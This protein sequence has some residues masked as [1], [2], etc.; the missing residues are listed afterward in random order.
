M[1]YPG[2]F[3]A[4]RPLADNIAM[5][6]SVFPD[7]MYTPDES[8]KVHQETT[9]HMART[10]AIEVFRDITGAF[11]WCTQ[12]LIPTTT[13]QIRSGHAFPWHES[14]DDLKVSFCLASFG[15]YK[16]AHNALRSALDLGLLLIY[17]NI[18]GDGHRAIKKWVRSR[19]STPFAKPVWK[20][21]SGHPNFRLFQQSFDLKEQYESLRALGDYVHTKGIDFS[22]ATTFPGSSLKLRGQR[23]NEHAFEAWRSE[24]EKTV[25]FLAICYLVRWPLGTVRYDWARKFGIDVPQFG[26]IP[27]N[28]VDLLEK[29]VSHEVFTKIAV[30]ANSDSHVAETMA[31]INGLPDLSK[32][33]IDNQVDKQARE[34][35]KEV[36]L[37]GWLKEI[38]EWR[39]G[40]PGDDDDWKAFEARNVRWANENGLASKKQ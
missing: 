15:M 23:F 32:D 2:R 4:L 16:H 7:N 30:I 31:W 8:W 40:A 21:V 5:E 11:F 10:G 14:Y 33:D 37:D 24:F 22:N 19:E 38:H 6:T 18:D 25:R 29:L 34:R 1:Y 26:G 35:I 28:W 27:A 20:R 12:G 17:W 36:G 3:V 13:A 39:R 9:A